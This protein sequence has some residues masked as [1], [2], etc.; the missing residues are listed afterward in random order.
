MEEHIKSQH[1]SQDQKV[2]DRNKSPTSSPSRK[3]IELD[4]PLDKQEPIDVNE[5]EIDDTPEEVEKNVKENHLRS[6]LLEKIQQLEL[7]IKQEKEENK[8]LLS[9]LT[10]LENVQKEKNVLNEHK[11]KRAKELFEIPKH[12][13][14]V[15]ENHKDK[16][17]GFKMRYCAIPNGA[18]LTNCL[19]AHISCTEDEE[20]R[21]INNRRVNNHI[22]DHFDDYY[23]KIIKL[24]Y[25]EV[26]G[27]GKGSRTVTCKTGEELKAF[28]RSEDS[29]CV[30]SNSQELLA[31]ANMLNIKVK[32]FSF[33]IG[34]DE[35]R[36]E[37]KEVHPDPEMLK[38]AIFPKGFV[39]DLFLYNSDQSHYDL[40]VDD[41]HKLAMLGLVEC[42]QAEKE[43]VSDEK[44][45]FNGWNVKKTK[46]NKLIPSEMLI[47]EDDQTEQYDELDLEELDEEVEIARGKKRGHRRT[48]PASPSEPESIKLNLY[49]CTWKNCDKKLESEGFLKAQI[50]EHKNIF[51]CKVCNESFP[52]ETDLKEYS[53]MK[54]EKNDWFCVICEEN[55][56]TESNLKK[57]QETYHDGKEWNCDGCSF[58]SNSS[59]ELINHLKLTG[60]QPS[61]S[62]Q[63]SKSKITHCYTCKEEFTSYW[64]LMNHRKQKHPSNKNCRYFLK[65]ECIHGNKCWYRHIEPMEVDEVPN[66]Y[67]QNSVEVKCQFCGQVFE[68]WDKLRE[69][70][71]TKHVTNT[72]AHRSQ[73]QMQQQKSTIESEQS[74]FRLPTFDLFPPDQTQEIMKTLQVGL[75]KMVMDMMEKFFQQKHQ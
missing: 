21:K 32:I 28:L 54:H 9:K 5:M 43:V 73:P 53:N 36:S 13:K 1:E 25:T 70:K 50:Q 71:R 18:C 63:N 20:E 3:K 19:T 75:Q 45:S 57:H 14:S 44:E 7:K 39:P 24:P 35:T 67:H 60:H 48:S 11:I 27:V 69:H 72:T 2:D 49:K 52:R 30:Y 16:L 38:F 31:I 40:L 64:N 58:Q 65:N 42:S 41:D 22:A 47:M 17:F 74:D 37:W 51:C 29:L 8:K 4:K 61:K 59:E 55:F 68:G 15:P 34:G 46:S 26:V 12:L 6:N 62:I 10:H 56:L 66:S 33:G 23:H